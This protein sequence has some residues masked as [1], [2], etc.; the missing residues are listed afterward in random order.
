MIRLFK[1]NLLSNSHKKPVFKQIHKYARIRNQKLD[2]FW[3]IWNNPDTFRE[4]IQNNTTHV[5]SKFISN[6][7]EEILQH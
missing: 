2:N 6:N 7:T 5:L 4:L 1:N 3:E